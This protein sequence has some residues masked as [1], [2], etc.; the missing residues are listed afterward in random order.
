[1]K[2]E[3]PIANKVRRYF[4]AVRNAYLKTL[5][6]W[7]SVESCKKA[8]EVVLDKQAKWA[9]T[10]CAKAV[11]MMIEKKDQ[12]LPAN[13]VRMIGGCPVGLSYRARDTDNM[14]FRLRYL[15]EER[16]GRP[17]RV[18]IDYRMRIRVGGMEFS[19]NI[20]VLD[21]VIQRA[22]RGHD[23]CQEGTRPPMAALDWLV[24]DI[25]A[26]WKSSSRAKQRVWA[27]KREKNQTRF[28]SLKERVRAGREP[29]EG[30]L[31]AINKEFLDYM[32]DE[33]RVPNIPD[34]LDLFNWAKRRKRY[35][36]PL[37]KKSKK[38]KVPFS[39]KKLDEWRQQMRGAV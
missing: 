35:L 25:R 14:Q 38:Q 30:Q 7:K 20:P 28:E 36:D 34:Y 22:P 21:V 2:T 10:E 5:R 16:D 11:T 17:H 3:T 31:G 39:Q 33:S 4:R 32:R 23:P 12:I 9:I 37:A 26:T 8:L 24:D 1:M 19:H 13:T 18:G 29:I 6:A 27:D 15:L